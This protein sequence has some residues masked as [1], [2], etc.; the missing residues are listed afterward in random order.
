MSAASQKLG[1]V[2]KASSIFGDDAVS[3]TCLRCFVMPL[4]EYCTPV[5]GSAAASHLNLLDRIVRMGD[6]LCGIRNLDLSHRRTVGSLSLLYKI[7]ENTAH[8]L[9]PSLPV[10]F[11]A[12]RET[13]A[14][15]LLHEWAFKLSHCRTFQFARCF[16]P[17]TVKLWNSLPAS[18]FAV[19]SLNCFK[20]RVN[21]YLLVP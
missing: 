7:T 1:I 12:V 19:D 21:R 2:R 20:S 14:T 6:G 11:C 18:V 3:S 4:L 16:I 9:H 5:W 13:R 17:N 15:A 10:P 8:S